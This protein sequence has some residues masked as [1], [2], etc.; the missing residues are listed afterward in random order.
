MPE[1]LYRREDGSTFT[2]RQ[3]FSD[4]PLIVD[5]DTGQKVVRVVQPTG[6]IFKGS[7]FYIND[8]KNASKSSLSNGSST[9]GSSDDKKDGKKKDDAKPA[10]AKS[11]TEATATESK[12]KGSTTSPSSTAAD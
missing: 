5:S 10:E 8:S 2:V 9:N 11:S 1:Y 4:D 7:G 6:L 3:K 12:S